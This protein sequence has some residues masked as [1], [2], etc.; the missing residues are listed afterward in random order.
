M[1]PGQPRPLSTNRGRRLA[2]QLSPK[3]NGKRFGGD[4]RPQLDEVEAPLPD[5]TPPRKL[6]STLNR[7]QFLRTLTPQEILRNRQFNE[8]FRERGLCLAVARTWGNRTLAVSSPEWRTLRQQVMER[9][10]WRCRFCGLRSLKW[11]VCDHIDGNASNNSPGNLGVNCPICDLLRHCGRAGLDGE[12]SL[13]WSRFSQ[14]DIVRK[15]QAFWRE[16]GSLPPP[17]KL[18]VRA[19]KV[20]DS[21]VGFANKLLRFNYSELT[22]EEREY[23]GFFEPRSVRVFERVIPRDVPSELR[24]RRP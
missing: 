1:N 14:L 5:D 20:A 10:D 22:A 18:D 6:D 11:M 16:N 23:K 21:T 9:D 12:L 15:T 17:R 4:P 2:H 19:R 8:E 3:Q 7:G 13:W 24:G